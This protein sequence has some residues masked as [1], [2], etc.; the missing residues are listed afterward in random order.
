MAR[1][2]GFSKLSGQAAEMALTSALTL[3][4]SRILRRSLGGRML[5]R[6]VMR[7]IR[8]WK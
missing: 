8:G 7:R 6:V 5:V 3:E 1:G 4:V 2:V